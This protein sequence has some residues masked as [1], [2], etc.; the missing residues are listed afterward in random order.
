MVARCARQLRT[1]RGL[2]SLT[3]VDSKES[4]RLANQLVTII[5]R[6]RIT[7]TVG[8]DPSENEEQ[9]DSD[10]PELE[11]QEIPITLVVNKYD[12]RDSGEV[13]HLDIKRLQ[14]E[15]GVSQ[16]RFYTIQH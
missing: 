15:T 13:R 7:N 8:A 2:K 12:L 3:S 6:S 16:Y 4:V 14:H 1:V 10:E 11:N 9:N 5:R